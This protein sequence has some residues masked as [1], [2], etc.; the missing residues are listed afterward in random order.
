MLSLQ[1]IERRAL[2]RTS[3]FACLGNPYLL[4][5]GLFLL[6]MVSLSF[7]IPGVHSVAMSAR[8][9]VLGFTAVVG[10]AATIFMGHR[11]WSGAHKALALFLAAVGLSA[12]Y[13]LD[14]EYSI[15]RGI[16][17]CLLFTA[18]LVGL[19]SYCRTWKHAII[20]TDLLWG[21]G[22]LLVVVGFVFRA[23]AGATGARYEGLHS[24]A[25]GA[26]TYAALFLPIAV[27]Q[28]SYRLNGLMKGFGWCVVLLMLAQTFL[29]GARMAALTGLFLAIALG[30][31]YNAKRATLA[32][33]ALL[34]LAPV[35]FIVE[36][37]NVDKLVEKSERLV[38]AESF[39]TF[40]G[41]LDRWM[42]GIEQWL[43]KPALGN[44]FGA[45]RTLAGQ[46][47]PRRFKLQP[48]ETFNLHSDQIE[49]LMDVGVVGYMPFAAFWGLLLYFGWKTIRSPRTIHRQMSLAY[50]GSLF[51]AFAD[52]FMHGG[53]LAAGG[54]V[55]AFSWSMIA[56]FLATRPTALRIPMPMPAPA[57]TRK[58]P[59]REDVEFGPPVEAPTAALPSARS[60]ARPTVGF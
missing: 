42:F 31:A 29:A 14:P 27:Y 9:P 36:P 55:S 10:L 60:F 44:G 41:R 28:A 57:A 40:T 17:I 34:F 18:T 16:S 48:G 49:V 3:L 53:F 54:G 24:R 50:L 33:I 12:T 37:K 38:R 15:Q 56:L 19:Y 51:Y 7:A 59:I 4:V 45:S 22:A 52:T 30:Y 43:K 11:T 1:A 46:E 39:G 58:R 23:S 26:G 13:S 21:F 32:L 20:A 47:D 8:W 35:P 5:Y 6:T 2:E 25:T